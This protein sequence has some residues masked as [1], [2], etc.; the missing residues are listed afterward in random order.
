MIRLELGA[1]PGTLRLTG[2]KGGSGRLL[3]KP[4][5]T[6]VLRPQRSPDGQ[7]VARLGRLLLP[8]PKGLDAQAGERLT[9]KVTGDA[10]QPVL[11]VIA[12]DRGPDTPQQTAQR[13]LVP[14]QQSLGTLLTSL[15]SASEPSG[16]SP[17]PDGIRQLVLGL[18][19]KTPTPEKL[20]TGDGLRQALRDSGVLLE[21]LLA[22]HPDQASDIA[23][24]DV[25]ASLARIASRLLAQQRGGDS[26]LHADTPSN[27][28]LR[29]LG[30]AVDGALARL[31]LMQLGNVGHTGR[32]DLHFALPVL[33]PD[34]QDE[35]TLRIREEDDDEDVDSEGRV[36]DASVWDVSLRLRFGERETLDARLR[37][38]GERVSVSWLAENE[39]VATR[40]EDALPRLSSS[41]ESLGLQVIHVSSRQGR[42]ATPPEPVPPRGMVSERA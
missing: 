6:L 40:I 19:A 21:S 28:G 9:V 30:D 8:L 25:K 14:R 5:Q 29:D 27:T 17:L 34:R 18:L 26:P 13:R 10:R 4:G 12:R 37:L 1:S 33:T 11:T 3:L 2:L 36:R 41:L 16:S 32:V 24:N 20:S 15:L 7:L 23:S 38:A 22:R 31:G 39:A 35:L 42:S